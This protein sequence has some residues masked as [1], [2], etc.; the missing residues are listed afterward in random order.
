MDGDYRRESLWLCLLMESKTQN[1]NRKKESFE[2]CHLKIAKSMPLDPLRMYYF[3]Q[4]M[5]PL[6][7]FSINHGTFFK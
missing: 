7:F 4:M 3:P 1:E 2:I 6:A 5:F